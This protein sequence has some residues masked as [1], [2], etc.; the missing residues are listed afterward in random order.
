MPTPAI[1]YWTQ[2]T[3]GQ[4]TFH[5]AA[6]PRG[7]CCITL[8]NE[9]LADLEAW[10]TR[11]M[12]GTALERDD[13]RLEN[14]RRQIAEYLQGQRRS[15]SL[16]L[17]VIG[18]DFQRQVWRQLAEIPYGRTCSY[19]DL[20]AAVGRPKA[21]RAVGMA[22]HANPLP[23]VIPCHRVI[24][25]DGSLVGY[26]GGLEMKETLLRLEGAWPVARDGDQS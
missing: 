5:L 26:G 17:D 2:L 22:N 6:T 10:V 25:A 13:D 15:F 20:A 18:T 4:W 14:S 1:V 19:R 12:P 16:P 21:V 7:L 24:G 3:H 23:L 11:R 9:T 8:P